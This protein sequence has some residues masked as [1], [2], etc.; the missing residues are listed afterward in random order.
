[1]KKT[2]IK[3]FA[4]AIA[5]PV[6]LGALAAFLTR[7]NMNIYDDIVVPPL[8]PPMKLFPIAWTILYILMGISSGLVFRQRILHTPYASREKRPTG[9]METSRSPGLSRTTARYQESEAAIKQKEAVFDALYVY[10]TQLFLNFFWSIF[11]FNMRTF[12]FAFIWLLML[13]IAVLVM[14]LKFKKLSTPAGLLQIPYLI[15]ISFAGYLNFA[16]YWLNM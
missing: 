3:Q 13:W 7:G 4:I 6:T 14:I 1:M 16:I 5:I 8:A 2:A 15:W 10:A 11:F 12:L 9:A